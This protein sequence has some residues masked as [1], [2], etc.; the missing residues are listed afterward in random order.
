[1]WSRQIA[2]AA[3]VSIP[4]YPN[5]HFYMITEDYKSLPKDLPTFRDPDTF[6]YAREYHG[7]MMLGIFE[8]NAKNAFK[9]TGK[10]P[11]NFSFGEFKVDKKNLILLGSI[12]YQL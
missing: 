11:N 3:G 4:L 12:F 6:L 5:E 10:V 2:E 8:P 9:K 1:M 7:K